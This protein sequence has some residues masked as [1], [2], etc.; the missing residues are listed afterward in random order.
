MRG[1]GGESDLYAIVKSAE[2]T[3]YIVILGATPDCEGQ[4]VCSFG[5]FIGTTRSLDQVD[6]YSVSGR[7]STPVNLQHGLKGHF[8]KSTCGAYCSDS[9]I[10]WTEG[11][12]NYIIGIKA[13][14]KADMIKTVNSAIEASWK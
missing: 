5:T 9:L 11:K 3:G 10:V 1:L 7:G 12:N 6:E 4:H 14:S 2:E 13:E 8:Y